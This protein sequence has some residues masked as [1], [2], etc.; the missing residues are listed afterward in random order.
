V[1]DQQHFFVRGC[2]EIPVHGHD[3]PFV[4]GVWASLSQPNFVEWL[5]QWD[6]D[7]RSH[8][9]PFFG[10]LDAWLKP[11]ADT[12]NLKTM[13]HLRD[14]GLRPLIELESTEHPLAVDQRNGITETRAQYLYETMMHERGHATSADLPIGIAVLDLNSGERVTP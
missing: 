2:I 14:H 11:Y 5:R 9:G 13:V 8:V 1:I 7:H 10:W 12:I 6:K 4:W 3:A